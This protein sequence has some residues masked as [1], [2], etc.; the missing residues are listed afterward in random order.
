MICSREVRPD[1]VGTWANVELELRRVGHL[2]GLLSRQSLCKFPREDG[3]LLP[4]IANSDDVHGPGYLRGSQEVSRRLALIPSIATPAKQNKL[5]PPS[6]REPPIR[7]ACCVPFEPDTT[8]Q[9]DNFLSWDPGHEFPH[10]QLQPSRDLTRKDSLVLYSAGICPAVPS[11][12][13][14][15]V[16]AYGNSA[17]F[18]PFRSVSRKYG[19][20]ITRYVVTKQ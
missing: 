7:R 16:A 14:F 20:V 15:C 11:P 13:P 12:P 5:T 6:S 17:A 18:C 2:R 3:G 10:S 1:T 9:P 4:T 8:H 19:V